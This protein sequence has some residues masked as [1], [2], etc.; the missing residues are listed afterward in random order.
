MRQRLCKQMILAVLICLSL[1][2]LAAATQLQMAPVE[3]D[4][5][6]SFLSNL[7]LQRQTTK[8]KNQPIECFAVR[9]DGTIAIGQDGNGEIKSISIY[10]SN[11]TFQYAY[12]F[13]TLGSFGLEWENHLLNL[14]LV[15]SDLAA[16][17]SGQGEIVQLRTILNTTENNT[18][19]NH[20][21]SSPQQTIGDTTY[22]LKN[23]LGFFN[24]F[25][26]S[27]TQLEIQPSSG[28]VQVIYDVNS[29][30]LVKCILIFLFAV[31]GTVFVV[32]Q[33]IQ[34][35]RRINQK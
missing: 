9:L 20:V 34:L 6:E 13:H 12:S 22:R 14:Y 11:G 7:E 35:F 2:S 16:S 33:I 18:Y 4:D 27:Y 19:W 28:P 15:R 26:S 32:F 29:D 25:T 21:I 30:Q 23:D 8:P 24:W 3:P 10:S 1:C 17:I 5:A 31:L